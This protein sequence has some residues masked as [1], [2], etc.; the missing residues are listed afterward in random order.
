[1]V[2]KNGR[3]KLTEL[4][5]R[6]GDSASQIF[7]GWIAGAFRAASAK[8]KNEVLDD[9]AASQKLKEIR[10]QILDGDGNVPEPLLRKPFRMDELATIVRSVLDD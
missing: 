9:E 6:I 5:V 8:L 4:E 10:E 2:F 1:M 3:K 7:D